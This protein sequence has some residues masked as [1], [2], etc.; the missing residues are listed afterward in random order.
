M[1]VVK[2]LTGGG[3]IIWALIDYFV[4]LINCLSKTPKL[5]AVS[6]DNTFTT[7]SI[8]SA[9]IFTAVFLAIKIL[10]SVA[11]AVKKAQGRAKVADE[12]PEPTQADYAKLLA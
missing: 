1:G 8:N 7:S 10:S 2:G 5:K 11:G 4:I 9:F 6:Y 12:I 3:F